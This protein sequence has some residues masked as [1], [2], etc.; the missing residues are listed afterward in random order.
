MCQSTFV[1]QWV[2]GLSSFF[3]QSS[4]VANE[5]N[6]LRRRAANPSREIL[7]VVCVGG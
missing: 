2:R 4:C 1:S 6:S 5:L 3:V 7:E